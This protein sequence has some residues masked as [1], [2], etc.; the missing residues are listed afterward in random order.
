MRKVVIVLGSPRKEG[1]STILAQKAAE[2]ARAAGADVTIFNIHEMNIGPCNACDSCI[3]K[4][5]DFCAIA[6]NMQSVYP[7]IR[8]ADALILASPIYVF[9]VS[10]QMKLFMDRCRPL[11]RQT[12]N[13]FAGMS[14]GIILTYKAPDLF[15]SGAINAI[16]TLQDTFKYLRADIMGMVYGSVHEPGEVRGKKELL[17]EAYSLGQK[18]AG[19]PEITPRP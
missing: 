2:G 11:W 1:N 14:A 18:L 9:T 8:Q 3:G 19:P 17:A 16:R 10:A 5:T 13:A 15:K 12:D 4:N 7:E 6:D